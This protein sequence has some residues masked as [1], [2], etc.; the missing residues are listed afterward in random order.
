MIRELSRPCIT[1]GIS[2]RLVADLA[3][4]AVTAVWGGTFVMMKEAVSAYPVFSFL[5][6]RFACAALVLLPFV[7]LQRQRAR[8][9]RWVFGPGRQPAS[10][11]LR[12]ISPHVSTPLA[13]R[14]GAVCRLWLS[15]GGP[16]TDYAC[17]NRL[18]HRSVDGDR[19]AGGGARVA[20]GPVGTPGSASAA[21][22]WAW[23][24]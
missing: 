24:S 3:L 1:S 17:Q 8:G 19:A 13:D 14:P 22:P 6:L 15:N 18:Y 21:R 10:F 12:P 7:V 16:A 11:P 4:L 20:P 9:G 5:A 2:R 23:H